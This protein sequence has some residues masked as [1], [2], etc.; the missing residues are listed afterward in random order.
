M[1]NA[2]AA[3]KLSLFFITM[4]F[5][6]SHM[7]AAPPV[8]WGEWIDNSESSTDCDVILSESIINLNDDG[9]DGVFIRAEFV[10]VCVTMTCCDTIIH[11]VGDNPRLYLEPM[12]GHTITCKV[13][14]DLGF[15]GATEDHPLLIVVR[16]DGIVKFEIS[17]T[18]TVS[19]LASADMDA[20]GA[21]LFVCMDSDPN[22]IAQLCFDRASK[23][24]SDNVNICV[25]RNSLITYLAQNTPH[26]STETGCIKFDPSNDGSGRMVVKVAD[27]GA[28]VIR[29]CQTDDCGKDQL[30]LADIDCT[31]LAGQDAIM[32]VINGVCNGTSNA[33]LLVLNSNNTWPE[34]LVDPFCNLEARED[35]IDYNGTFNG[36]QYGFILGANATFTVG[37]DAFL[38]YVALT[39]T[40]CIEIDGMDAAWTASMLK[41]RNASAFIIDGSFDPASTPAKISFANQAAI[42]LRSGVDRFGNIRPI[43]DDHPFTI[44]P[45]FRTPGAGDTVMHIEG[46]L[47]VCGANLSS[48]SPD[49]LQSMI[50]VLSLE[51]DH[52]GG[53]LFVGTN[54]TVF[55]LRTFAEDSLDGFY[56]YN[57]A[58][59]MVNNCWNLFN[60]ALKHTDE[61]H[62]VLEKNDAC[63]EPT[64][65]GGETAVLKNELFKERLS[66]Y[67]SVLL[68]HTDIA[69][70]GFDL[71]TP[72]G[73][74]P[75]TG[76]CIDN[77]SRF[78]FFQNGKRI[79][80]GTGR[81]MILGTQIGSTAC[82]GCTVVCRDAH[83]DVMQNS[84]CTGGDQLTEELQ[85]KVQANNDTINNQISGD[86]D[87]QTAIHTIY[88]GNNSN[89]SVGTNDT[90]NSSMGTDKNNNMFPLTTLPKFTVCGN[91]FSFETKGGSLGLPSTANVTGQGG[92]FVD[93][94]GTFCLASGFRAYFGSMITK[95]H[96]GIINVPKDC[97][98]FESCVG[99]SDWNLNLADQQIIVPFSFCLSEYT[100][101]WMFVQKDYEGGFCPYE[102]TDCGG[103][104]CPP[105]VDDN[106]FNLPE[107]RGEVDQLQI[108][109]SRLGDQAHVFINGGIVRELV[110]CVGF[111]SAE[112]PVAMVVLD[113]GGRIGLGST[114]KN[115]DSL[116]ANSK[117]GV[118]GVTV[119][120][121]G[122]GVIELNDDVVIDNDCAFLA[123]PGFSAGGALRIG[124][125][126]GKVLRLKST[127]VLDMRSFT[128]GQN[129]EFT[130]DLQVV[131]E[132]GARIIWGGDIHT[133]GGTL[134]FKDNTQL[135]LEP[136]VNAYAIDSAVDIPES[137]LDFPAS[138]IDNP[139]ATL[140]QSNFRRVTMIG[141]GR[142]EFVN[143]SQMSI[144]RGAALGIE[145]YAPCN[146]D[147]TDITW[148][149]QDN[150]RITVGDDRIAGFGGCFQVGN[151]VDRSGHSISFNLILN[152]NE[153]TFE[154]GAQGFVGLAV[155]CVCKLFNAPNNWQVA[156]LWN[157]DNINLTLTNGRF[158]HTHI[159]SGDDEQAALIAMS[160]GVEGNANYTVIVSPIIDE[161][162]QLSRTSILGGGNIVNVE[163]TS[164][165]IMPVVTDNDGVI[166]SDYQAGVLASTRNLSGTASGSTS[167]NVFAFVKLKDLRVSQPVTGKAVAAI[168]QK[169]HNLLNAAWIN[170]G[171]I[172]RESFSNLVS[173]GGKLIS[174]LQ[175]TLSGSISVGLQQGQPA[176][177][178]LRYV[179]QTP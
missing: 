76:D 48:T 57:A 68:V 132:P 133:E 147:F 114:E 166:T 41:A 112:A 143:N 63:S 155:G 36:V 144:P 161:D 178:K 71:E 22:H 35:T 131:V 113:N 106:I 104:D 101:N 137:T 90:I 172:G 23:D 165:A 77:L 156:P 81:Q 122:G 83:L 94:N 146:I 176:P 130:G 79:D 116:R 169:S 157:V 100:L 97:V 30:L 50:E 141:R 6:F 149:I 20:A 160:D 84:A 85:L 2:K 89:I 4:I 45:L 21:K 78:Y 118:N 3:A 75:V 32:K 93:E 124:S 72:N 103:C 88:L 173:T 162:G 98:L 111:N 8:I 42:Y 119:V 167:D 134:R 67:N 59:I 14:N 70:T 1:R 92:I 28:I 49:G 69:F 80:Q 40:A 15:Q 39:S 33:G 99:I 171:K 44:D 52:T 58:N 55:P 151:V 128:L 17:D 53:P 37:Q 82:D 154:V 27:Q 159:W 10:D 5:S 25:E 91:F 142:L 135:V 65:I 117:L 86:I 140:S 120:V 19:F 24:S 107:I 177:G 95:S 152:G 164:G 168:N 87:G 170:A 7:Y 29:G 105:V 126:K 163:G 74:D 110:H 18:K 64:Y 109:G 129:I 73:L 51:V 153:A 56:Q 125:N 47:D 138:C 145:T 174:H 11:G 96:N 16:G 127:A 12:N 61:I 148:S 54:E 26:V 179:V 139:L 13:A 60:T 62:K 46:Q 121:N 175:T 43:T 136:A 9:G 102:I 108:K 38:D 66:F 123:G 34:L 150:A 31:V 158:K 115:T